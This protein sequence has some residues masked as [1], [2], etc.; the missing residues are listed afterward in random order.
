MNPTFASHA[1]A[2]QNWPLVAAGAL[3][4]C[5]AIGVVFSLAV[6]LDPMST[7]TGWSR[8]AASSRR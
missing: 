1:P 3:M 4:T 7:D 2:P 5:V 8:Q 6:F